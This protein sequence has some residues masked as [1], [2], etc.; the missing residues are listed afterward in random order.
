MNTLSKLSRKF[1]RDIQD[2]EARKS[3]CLWLVIVFFGILI[4]CLIIV[5][6]EKIYSYF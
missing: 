6:M 4:F 2:Q 5:M 3:M 1:I